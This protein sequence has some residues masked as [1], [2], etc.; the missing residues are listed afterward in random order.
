MAINS[1]VSFVKLFKKSFALYVESGMRE[2]T[3]A[4][5]DILRNELEGHVGPVTQ[6]FKARFQ[7]VI[8]EHLLRKFLFLVFALDTSNR[9]FA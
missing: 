5:I 2:K 1:D 6:D 4:D 7:E 9:F 8:M 3:E